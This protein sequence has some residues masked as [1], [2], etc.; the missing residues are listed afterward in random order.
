MFGYVRADYSHRNT[1]ICRCANCVEGFRAF[2]GG[3]D[4]PTAT[5]VSDPVYRAYQR[6]QDATI[7]ALSRKIY[8]TVKR[9]RPTAGIANIA[10]A[11]DFA[12]T[13]ANHSV[14]RAQPEWAY[15]S[16]EQARSARSVGV[17]A[18]YSASIV[19]FFDFPW[20]YTAELAGCQGLRLAQQLA[21][22]GSPHYY[23]LGTFDQEDTK[24]L[25]VVRWFFAHH[26]AHEAVYASLELAARI[27]VYHSL[28]TERYGLRDQGRDVHRETSAAFRGAFRSLLESGLV[29]DTISDR[30]AADPTFPDT[31]ARYEVIVLPDVICMSDE[32]AAALDG[33]V[34]QGG[35]LIVTGTTGTANAIGEPRAE[36]ALLSLPF[37]GPLTPMQDM[38]G[39][40]F[41]IA[42]DEL[43]FPQTRLM[44]LDETYWQGEPK[45]GSETLLRLLLPQRFGPPE[46]RHPEAG[47]TNQPGVIIGTTGPRA[48][49]GSAMVAGRAL[50]PPWIGRAPAPPRATCVAL[51]ACAGET[52]GDQPPRTDAAAE[53]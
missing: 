13:E 30:R 9:V 16:G 50:P 28:K 40:Y 4:L 7:A 26:A 6:F 53:Q 3:M 36:N 33:F 39:A 49:R 37:T 42:P 52:L 2:S 20:R 32:E 1:G 25:D 15:Q 43:D 44:M 35:V 34:E 45:A 19:H 51:L 27:G 47:P 21:N 5:E 41:T 46:L 31:L 23:F 10:G 14:V 17:G 29:F 8:D 38:R 11:R 22:G 18:P 12:R 48:L 24:P